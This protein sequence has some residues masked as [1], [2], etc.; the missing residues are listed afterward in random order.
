MNM[1]KDCITFYDT[2]GILTT[3]GYLGFSE[4]TCYLGH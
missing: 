2:A 4:D 3:V 1:D